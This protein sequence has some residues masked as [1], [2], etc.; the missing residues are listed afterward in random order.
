MKKI[1]IIFLSLMSL[2]GCNKDGAAV[3]EEDYDKLFPFEGIDEY[4]DEDGEIV[5]QNADPNIT[6][7]TFEYKGKDDVYE[8]T[9]Y[10][11]VL[12]YVFED[13]N[14][15]QGMPSRYFVRFVDE[16]KE[17]VS[18]S[19]I[20]GTHFMDPEEYEELNGAPAHAYEMEE[21]KTYEVKF[22]VQSG[23][24]LL[25]CVNGYGPRNTSMKASL[26]ATATDDS[27]EPIVLHTEQYQNDEGQVSLPYP[28]CKYVILP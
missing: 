23:H 7:K 21:G 15:N 8:A 2:C 26:T 3:I 13:K 18:I 14:P 20:P 10:E 12:K 22:Q 17:L 25:L 5:I 11:V 1:A 9:T 24:Q 27:T 16:T 6:K 4:E 19:S 28:Y